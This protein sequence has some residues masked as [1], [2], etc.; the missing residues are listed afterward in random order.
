MNEFAAELC[1]SDNAR[2]ITEIRAL[3]ESYAR[4]LV[5]VA[6]MERELARANQ[7]LRARNAELNHER[8][9]LDALLSS[10]PTGVIF[11]DNDGRI[12][13]ANRKAAESIG[14]GA[15]QLTDRSLQDIK[16]HLGTELLTGRPGEREYEITEGATRILSRTR[17]NVTTAEGQCIG[18]V[19]LLE[20]RTDRRRL[21][22]QVAHREKLALVGEMSATVAHEVRNPLHSIEGF[23]SLLLR[24]AQDDAPNAKLRNYASQIVRGVRDLNSVVTNLL[25]FARCD[26]FQAQTADVVLIVKR[27]AEK[28]K[29]SLSP[30]NIK[31]YPFEFHA[32][33]TLMGTVDEIQ[34]THAV[35]NLLNNAIEAMPDGGRVDVRVD[36][37]QSGIAIRVSDEGP[38]VRPDVRHRIFQP[39][40]TTKSRGTGLGLAVVAKAAALHG[41]RVYLDPS[42]RG[43]AFTLWFPQCNSQQEN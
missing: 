12:L 43:A 3:H 28:V 24:A 5:R 2:E 16:S 29:M 19:D 39:F 27:C 36:E 40:F 20:D 38:G 11:A 35:K 1:T 30:E 4:L 42:V 9:S 26:R 14:S 10:M 23:A 8:A 31:K 7:E 25:D 32:P 37:Q 41:G 17:A 33:R 34:L 21:E 6:A 15:N 22:Q 13:R 18:T